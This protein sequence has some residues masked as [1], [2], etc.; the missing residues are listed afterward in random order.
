MS[1]LPSSRQLTPNFFGSRFLLVI[2][3]LQVSEGMRI[4][5][6]KPHHRRTRAILFSPRIALRKRSFTSQSY[7][8]I[9]S[10]RPQC[11]NQHCD[12]A[13]GKDRDDAEKVDLRTAGLSFEKQVIE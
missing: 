7:Q 13:E 12:P 6:A 1:A 10:Y 5:F 8:G 11:R 9:N 4:P 3:G 2:T